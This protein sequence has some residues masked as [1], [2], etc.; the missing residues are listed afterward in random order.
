MKRRTLD[1]EK[2]EVGISLLSED[3]EDLSF[4][5]LLDSETA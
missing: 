4:A 2:T 3:E 1:P 5:R